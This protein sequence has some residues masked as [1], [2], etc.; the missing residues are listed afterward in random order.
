M[1]PINLTHCRI[2]RAP[3]R[4]IGRHGVLVAYRCPRTG[5]LWQTV[6]PARAAA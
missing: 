3:G 1:I 4:L 6:I 5:K 2:C